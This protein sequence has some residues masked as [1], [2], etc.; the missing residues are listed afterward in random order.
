MNNLISQIQSLL[1]KKN[2]AINVEKKHIRHDIR[3]LKRMISDEQKQL[4]AITVFKKI[5]LMPEFKTANTILIYWATSDELPT[6]TTI[7]SW[8]KEKQ[9][10][11]PAIEGNRLVLKRYLPEGKLIQK[12][13]GIW[14]PDMTEE[15]KGKIDLVIVPGVAFDK[16]KN[17]LGRGKGYYDRFFKKHMPVKIGV[18]FDFQLISLV[19]VSK[20]DIPMDKIVTPSQT[21]S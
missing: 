10:L 7:G 9:M 19:P 3:A 6:Q 17:R 5:E 12:N 15:Y 8:C 16:G 14:E 21:I 13:L 11:L 1:F 18:G 20:H 2:A 4:E